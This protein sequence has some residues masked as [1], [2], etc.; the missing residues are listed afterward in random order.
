MKTQNSPANHGIRA[1]G[2][3]SEELIDTP[4]AMLNVF[5]VSV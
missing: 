1:R 2:V 5:N 3:G 4:T